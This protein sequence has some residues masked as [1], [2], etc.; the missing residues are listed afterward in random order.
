MI[1][2]LHQ[3]PRDVLP[4]LRQSLLELLLKFKNGPKP[5]RT[6]LCI[7]LAHLAIQ[8]TEWKN[9]LQS[10]MEAFSHEGSGATSCFLEFLKV[11]SEE[12]TEGRKINLS[13]C[14]TSISAPHCHISPFVGTVVQV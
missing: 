9:V 1:N 6:Q 11:L 10:M 4:S 12:I 13:V 3:V 7:A 8:M 2:D 14:S 5:I